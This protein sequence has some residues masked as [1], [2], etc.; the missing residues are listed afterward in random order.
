MYGGGGIEPDIVVERPVA[1]TFVR[2]LIRQHMI[3]DFATHF[4]RRHESIPDAREFYVSDDM[5]QDFLDFIAGKEFSYHTRSENILKELRNT[6]RKET[7]YEAL[8]PEIERLEALIEKEKS[9]DHET[10]REEVGQM[11]L[12]EI[13][14]RFY[15]Q[16]GRV[17]VSLDADP[18]I[19]RAI[20][21]LADQPVYQDILAAEQ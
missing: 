20:E 4:Q 18:D 6:A 8:A 2:E 16:E 13:V 5:Y 3:F 14:A 19:I 10:Y 11:L 21:V 9:R 15:Y 17:I 1:G 7:Y 12:E